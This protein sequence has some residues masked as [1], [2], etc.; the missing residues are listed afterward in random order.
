MFECTF[1]AVLCDVGIS[2][3]SQGSLAAHNTRYFFLWV[4]RWTGNSIASRFIEVEQSAIPIFTTARDGLRVHV[5]ALKRTAVLM[6]VVF[7]HE[8]S[9]VLQSPVWRTREFGRQH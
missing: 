1:T 6:G 5:H 3:V 2:V 9:I 4:V 8:V 7:R